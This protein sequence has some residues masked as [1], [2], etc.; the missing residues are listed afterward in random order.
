MII[1]R[2]MF[3][4]LS[5]ACTIS[6]AA[7]EPMTDVSL[8]QAAGQAAYH[9]KYITPSGSGTG[10]SPTDFGFY[11]L[12]I[13]ASVQLNLNIRSLKLGC[14]GPNGT[15]TCD[16]DIDHFSV[17]GN[18][19]SRDGRVTSDAVLTNP[20]IEF[21]I[22]NPNSASTRE[23]T[24]FRLGSDS[25]IGLLTAGTENSSTPNGI[26]QFSGFLQIQSGVGSTA[27]ERSKVKGLANT[28]ASYFD[29][30]L[31]QITGRL[32]AIG[33][34]D[35]KFRTTSGGFNIAAMQN[36][37]FETNQIVVSQSRVS[38]VP[39]ASVINVPQIRLGNGYSAAG[40]PINQTVNGVDNTTIRMDTRGGPVNAV[41]TGCSNTVFFIPACLAAP[42]GRNF[43]NI[44]M[45]GSV[46]NIKA[47]V[48]INQDLGY[49]HSLP[50]NSPFSLSLQRQAV[51]W[52]D[53]VAADIAQKGWWMSFSDPVN[54]GNII[55][56]DLIDISPLF[57]QLKTEISNYLQD[58]PATTSDLAGII[59][60]NG[61]DA[62][63]GAVDLATSPLSLVL[64]NLQLNG[65]NFAPNCYGSLTFC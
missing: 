56:T 31:N 2:W 14:D 16:I 64:S 61:L 53:A 57:P 21:A 49:I 55:P 28:S 6:H 33:L 13:D 37:P 40:Q 54:L 23:L 1:N 11:R 32:V 8:A 25:A 17:S 59:S 44:N 35:A 10:A 63:I 12:G 20:F 39:I 51:R 52:P 43:S 34:A 60:G 38:S 24:G 29:A 18:A 46:N 4:V 30:G 7:L 47:N 9:F 22:K 36:L 5:G 58:N 41:I 15:G 42:T 3:W 19:L 65:Q 27:A 62:N 48:T 50:I 26:N 45:T